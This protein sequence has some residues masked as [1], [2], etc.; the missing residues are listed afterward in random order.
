TFYGM[1]NLAAGFDNEFPWELPPTFVAREQQL[2]KSIPLNFV[3]TNDITG[4][5]SGSPLIDREMRV[6]GL[7]FDSNVEGLPNEFLFRPDSGGRRG[8]V[9]AAGI[10]EALRSVYQATALVNEILANA[11]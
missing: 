3:S 6:V 2:D 1:Y 7:A 8:S 5:N 4:G 11:R 9:A 10:L